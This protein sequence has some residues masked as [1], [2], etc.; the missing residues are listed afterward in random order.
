MSRPLY[1]IDASVYLFRAFFSLP[2]S[3]K[4]ARG[5]SANVIYG[6]TDFLIRFRKLSQAT[7]A[8][9][10]FDE[11]LTTSFRNEIDPNYKANRPEA[12]E[13]LKRQIGACKEVGSWM[14]FAVYSSPRYEA[15]DLIGSLAKQFK[16]K[17]KNGAV[18]I[19]STDKDLL[20][21]LEPG[22]EFWNF[23]KDE[24]FKGKDVVK[25]MGVNANQVADFLAITGDS[26]DNIPGLPG[27]GKTTAAALL[28][29]FK[30]LDKLLTNLSRLKT[31]SMR[32]AARFHDIISENRDLLD[33]ARKLTL[34]E[35]GLKVEKDLGK[36]NLGSP[37]LKSLNGFFED[38]G[39]GQRLL[40]RIEPQS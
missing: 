37:D 39:I 10:C 6:F 28:N 5:R 2:D 13:D 15:D 32:G 17:E 30:S 24:R 18:C 19:V 31:H 33:R 25:K 1:L 22:D 21:V 3:M 9:L 38:L 7:R 16:E 12:P 36:L 34:I 23:S 40:S 35:T 4:D 29:E 27:I 20:Q 26:V 11:S 14:G 8:A